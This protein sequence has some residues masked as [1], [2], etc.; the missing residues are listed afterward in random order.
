MSYYVEETDQA[1]ILSLQKTSAGYSDRIAVLE[2]KVAESGV[3][4]Q[5]THIGT[6]ASL[7]TNNS[8]TNNNLRLIDRFAGKA[9]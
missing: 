9:T 2:H 8:S 4:F 1:R 5:P 7:K 6:N 3:Q